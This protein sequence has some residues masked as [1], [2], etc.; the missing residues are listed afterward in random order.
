MIEKVSLMLIHVVQPNETIASIAQQ[1]GVSIQR[2]MYDNEV[3]DE[4]QLV[5]G[6]ALLVL[7]PSKIHLVREGDTLYSIA[8][9]FQVSV[10]SLVRNNPYVIEQE[11]L[12]PGQTIVITYNTQKE[13]MIETGGY[14]YP[15]VTYDVLVQTLPYLN[16]ISIFSYGFTMEGELIP[17]DDEDIIEIAR[18]Y[19]VDPILVLTPLDVNGTFNNELV[20]VISSNQEVQQNLIQN[21]L[22]VVEEKKY[23]G[24]NVDFEFIKGEDAEGF[25]AFVRNLRE[26]MNEQGYTVSVALAPK[27]SADQPGLVYEGMN[28]ALLGEAANSAFLMTYE[29]GYT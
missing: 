25:A 5:V 2:L 8:R 22:Q 29:W 28:Y 19:G 13:R 11:G 27:T 23:S 20:A 4:T 6:Q 24:V 26:Q 1:Y 18:K 9:D 16:T 10:I 12:I 7:F 14:V 15:H 3:Y 21:L 17:T